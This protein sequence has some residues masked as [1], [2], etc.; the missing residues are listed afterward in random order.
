MVLLNTGLE[1]LA[2]DYYANDF[3]EFI[4][5]YILSGNMYAERHILPIDFVVF[6]FVPLALFLLS[7]RGFQLIEIRKD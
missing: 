5:T 6:I 7:I 3:W 1:L 2:I 4:V